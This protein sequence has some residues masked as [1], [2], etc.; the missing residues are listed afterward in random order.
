MPSRAKRGALQVT[1]RPASPELWYDL[2]AFQVSPPALPTRLCR[3]G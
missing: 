2:G 1:M 3:V